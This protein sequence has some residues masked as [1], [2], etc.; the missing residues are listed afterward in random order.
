MRN[1]FPVLHVI[2]WI[3]RVLGV[4]VLI[5]SLVAGIAGLVGGFTRGFGMM[6]R[7]QFAPMMGYRGGFI[8]LISGFL[9]GI[10]L[11]GF[12]EV[13]AVLLSIEENTRAGRRLV[14]EKAQTPPESPVISG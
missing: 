10:F 13:I 1:K 9:G 12:G 7:Y 4:L 6:D 3:F 2:V 14:E 5:V 8:Q 11:Y